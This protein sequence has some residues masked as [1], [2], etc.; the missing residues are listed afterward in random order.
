WRALPA[1]PG[2]ARRR[3]LRVRSR[4]G[5]AAPRSRRHRRR[6]K[7]PPVDPTG[8][9]PVAAGAANRIYNGRM[10][11]PPGASAA[12]RA[13][14]SPARLLL[15][16]LLSAVLLPPAALVAQEPGVPVQVLVHGG[17][18]SLRPGMLDAAGEQ[19]VREAL[20]AALF[21]AWDVLDAGG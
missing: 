1:P 13:L 21:A 7:C 6:R 8:A 20:A 11:V 12:P 18:G 14:R 3:R 2:A 10:R 17:A 16:L 19:A 4:E 9:R 15:G 5:S